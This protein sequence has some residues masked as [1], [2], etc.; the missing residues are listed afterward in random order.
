MLFLWGRWINSPNFN[1]HLWFLIFGSHVISFWAAALAVPSRAHAT[2]RV[3]TSCKSN[4]NI[5]LHA[6]A[7]VL[8]LAPRWLSDFQWALHPVFNEVVSSGLSFLS[9]SQLYRLKIHQPGIIFPKQ[10]ASQLLLIGR[11][12]AGQLLNPP[13]ERAS[14]A[15][16]NLKVLSIAR[17]TAWIR[18]STCNS[19]DILRL[20][21]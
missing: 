5:T 9:T 16:S 6:F 17:W 14:K 3:R 15:A 21:L 12:A 4:G 18:N 11:I 8:S 19:Y 20:R 7:H 10:V 1:D 2:T 13:A